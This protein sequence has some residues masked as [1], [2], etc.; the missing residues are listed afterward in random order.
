MRIRQNFR[1]LKRFLGTTNINEIIET[2]Y[3]ER[4]ID[5]DIYQTMKSLHGSV[6]QCESILKRVCE[7]DEAKCWKFLNLLS[8][9]DIRTL[10]KPGK[11]I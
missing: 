8:G 2:S 7:T 4:L 10:L 5:H 3:R 11:V 6:L 9:F 1:C